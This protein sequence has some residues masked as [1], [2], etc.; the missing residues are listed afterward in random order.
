MERMKLSSSPHLDQSVMQA[1]AVRQQF[2]ASGGSVIQ[3]FGQ[4]LAAIFVVLEAEF[5]VTGD[6]NFVSMWEF[7]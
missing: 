7:A 4:A 6:N 2:V 5:M 3:V 1:R